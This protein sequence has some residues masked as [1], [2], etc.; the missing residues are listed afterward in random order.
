MKLYTLLY[1]VP[2]HDYDPMMVMAGDLV[3]E[4]TDEQGLGMG[5]GVD[6]V[7]REGSSNGAGVDGG[8]DSSTVFTDDIIAIVD[9][10]DGGIDGGI[11]E[12]IPSSSSSSSSS[13]SFTPVVRMLTVKEVDSLTI[14][15]R[16]TLF[17]GDSLLPYVTLAL[18]IIYPMF[19]HIIPR[20]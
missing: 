16:R 20:L 15:Q 2:G 17:R 12:C 19:I 11:H 10:D 7:P 3:M 1:Y 13:S 18:V 5:L 8:G 4:T 6:K 9:G 14:E